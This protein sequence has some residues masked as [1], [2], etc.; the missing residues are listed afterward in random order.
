MKIL[1]CN[2]TECQ[3]A[4]VLLAE[5][6]RVCKCGLSSGRLLEGVAHIVGSHATTMDMPMNNFIGLLEFFKDPSRIHKLKKGLISDEEKVF[7][8][9]VINYF[10]KQAGTTF[11]TTFPSHSSGLILQRKLECKC[12]LEDFY[13]VIDKK[14][15]QWKGTDYE[16]FLT[17]TTLFAKKHFAIYLGQ[18]SN[19]KKRDT[20]TFGTFADTIR[21]AK[22]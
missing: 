16:N 10:N 12:G 1:F 19:V 7:C 6:A 21:A 17:P 5:K 9:Q 2:N 15:S 8:V 14:V 13:A 4:F 11:L 20:N 22:R 18:L 3:D